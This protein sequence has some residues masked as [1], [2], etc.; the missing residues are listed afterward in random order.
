MSA[1]RWGTIGT[2]VVFGTLGGGMAAQEAS[3]KAVT[4]AAVVARIDDREV[5]LDDGASLQVPATAHTFTLGFKPEKGLR[6]RFRLEGLDPAWREGPGEMAFRIRFA[7]ANGEQIDNVAFHMAGESAGWSGDLKNPTFVPRR[8]K[9]VVPQG[10]TAFWLEISSAG[11]PATLGV[12]LV[13]EMAV[14]RAGK[15]GEEETLIRGPYGRQIDLRFPN[16]PAPVGFISD[17]PRPSMARL[18]TL[19]PSPG[20]PLVDC[21]AIFD[22]DPGTH[23]EWHTIKQDSPRVVA[24]EALTV[25]WQEAFSVGFGDAWEATYFP[26]QGGEYR[27]HLQQ[28]DTVG[29]PLGGETAVLVRVLT[30]WW[31][32]WWV[33]AGALVTVAAG[34]FAI[35]RHVTQRR[36]RQQ[37]LHLEEDRLIEQERLRIARDIHD[38]LA[39]G[40]TGVIIQLEAAEDAQVR[41]LMQ[42]C[43]RH[44]HRAQELARDSLHEARRS[45]RALRPQALERQHLC[46]ALSELV[47]KMTAGISL[48]ASFRVEGQPLAMP[49]GCEDNLLRICQEVL[50]NALR[51]AEA[52]HFDCALIFAPNGVILEL[53][54]DGRGFDSNE[55]HEGFGLLGIKERIQQMDGELTIRS[56]PGEGT[57]IRVRL[58]AAQWK[59]VS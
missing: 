1:A 25:A 51:H 35:S 17:G 14:I 53:R 43:S 23:A 39:Q 32:R 12:L 3:Q 8:E 13:K 20:A 38:T 55:S 10:A 52:K 2:L 22:E 58:P 9:I 41:G 7:N 42:E 44:I 34:A 40:F 24:G 46:A 26:P 50:T 4:A 56:A 21:L 45:V 15:N 54:D 31:E 6:A 19:A 5:A 28:L 48:E 16:S 49:P 37:L 18:V 47:D 57:Q 59:P 11:P 36:M 27:F 30:P 33:L 29:Q